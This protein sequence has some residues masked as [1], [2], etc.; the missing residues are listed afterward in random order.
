MSS[1]DWW[2]RGAKHLREE[3]KQVGVD[4]RLRDAQR[5]QFLAET[6]YNRYDQYLP[7]ETFQY[8]LIKWLVNFDKKDRDTAMEVVDNLVYLDNHQLRALAVSTF[9]NSLRAIQD[10]V[11]NDLK[12]KRVLQIHLQK[13]DGQTLEALKRS[14]YIA[15]ADDVMFDY[16]RRRAQ[17]RVQDFAKDNFVEY[18]KLHEQC[19]KDDLNNLENIDRIFLIDQLCGSGTTFLRKENGN[20]K[21]KIDRFF[22]IWGN[23]ESKRIYYMPYI[24]SSVG[25]VRVMTILEEW[26][27][28]E[29]VGQQIDVIPTLEVP[30]SS[31]LSENPYGPIDMKKPVAGLCE[32]YFK[33]CI[34]DEHTRR[35]GECKWGFGGAGLALVINTNCPNNTM[36][37]VWCNCDGWFPLFP[38]LEHHP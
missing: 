38:R 9:W 23:L 22:D 6:K 30:M 35:G 24:M 7:G 17:R 12:G 2:T 5:I 3:L 15:V 27:K 25:N 8:R 26:K 19:Q 33:D 32:K 13:R 18:Y 31:C 10:D 21:G 20:W 37:V 16:F 34:L 36:P 14:V 28:E 11:L 4:R 1:N 29:E